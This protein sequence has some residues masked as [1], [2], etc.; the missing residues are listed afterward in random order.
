MRPLRGL[1]WPL[2]F[3]CTLAASCQSTTQPHANPYEDSPA[4]D[5]ARPTVTNPA[6]IPP[7]G[8]LQ[9]EQGFLQANDSYGINHQS[10][11]VQ[12]TKLSLSHYIMIV[13]GD[14]PYAYT[15]QP[16]TTNDTGDL[17]L[18]GQILFNDEEEG[19]ASRP[20]FAVAYNGRIRSGT[21]PNLDTGGFSQSFLF[22]ISGTNF[23]IHYDTNYLV[24]EQD[25][26][27]TGGRDAHRAQYG[28]TLSLTRQVTA[29]FSISAE[30]WHFTQ[31]TVFNTREGIPVGRSNAVGAL[32]AAG[33]NVR[34]TLVLDCG[35]EHGLTS[36]STNWQGFFGFTYLLPHRLFKPHGGKKS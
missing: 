2:A 7:P 8:Y 14:Q 15:N 34:P 28:Q 12:T 30:L 22:L 13:A 23:G 6:H 36:T 5:P 18:G 10:S 25:A 16:P 24:N 20:T 3:S 4:A 21:A 29:P 31:P 1:L 26:T 9:F 33:Y 17:Y 11:I 32:F 35:F 27:G 19:H